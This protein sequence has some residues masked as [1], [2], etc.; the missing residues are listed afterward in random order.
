MMVI[1]LLEVVCYGI[2]KWITLW[3]LGAVDDTGGANVIHIFGAFF[4]IGC[5][6]VAS[7]KVIRTFS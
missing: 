3:I 6:L 1:A 5:S 7:L 2:N 4:G